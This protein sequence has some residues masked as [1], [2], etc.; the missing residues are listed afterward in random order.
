MLLRPG[1]LTTK[2]KCLPGKHFSPEFK[3]YLAARKI[4]RQLPARN[5]PHDHSSAQKATHLT[6]K[7]SLHS[8]KKIYTNMPETERVRHVLKG[9]AEEAVTFFILQPPADV[10]AIMTIC[11]S[12]EAARRQRIPA[13]LTQPACSCRHTL[14]CSK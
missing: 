11:Q 14:S 7:M 10:S 9:I 8:V 5:W 3:R 1:F 13:A 2:R 6:L 4:A 12:L